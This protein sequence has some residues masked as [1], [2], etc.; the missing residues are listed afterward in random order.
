MV[1]DTWYSLRRNDELNS[2]EE[3]SEK[4]KAVTKQEIIDV[5]RKFKLDTV[6]TLVPEGENEN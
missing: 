1:L 2:P 4:I 3:F 5:A 6:F